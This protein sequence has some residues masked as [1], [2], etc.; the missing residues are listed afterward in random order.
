[1]PPHSSVA[2]CNMMELTIANKPLTTTTTTMVRNVTVIH[3][4]T[5]PRSRSTALLYSFEAR[6]DCVVLDEPL[7]RLFIS[8]RPNMHRVY[9]DNLVNGIAPDYEEEASSYKWAREL[10]PFEDRIQDAIAK[11][12]LK[13]KSEHE[14]HGGFIFCKHLSKQAT[15]Y[16]RA[17]FESKTIRQAL[18]ESGGEVRITHRHV[19]LL[20]DP[21]A[22]LS[23][24]DENGDIHFNCPCMEQVGIVP[25]LNIYASLQE[26]ALSKLKA[27]N[28]NN[29]NN[30]NND[31]IVFVDSDEL[32]ADPAGILADLCADVGISFTTEMLSWKSGSHECDGPWAPWWYASI[33]KSTH[34]VVKASEHAKAKIGELTG[35]V[36]PLY[37]NTLEASMPSYV[38][39]KI[40][41]DKDHRLRRPTKQTLP[42]KHVQQHGFVSTCTTTSTTTSSGGGNGTTGTEQ[43]SSMVWMDT[44]DRSFLAPREAGEIAMIP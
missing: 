23:S 9:K 22:I 42:N 39:L 40:L 31:A 21:V 12:K 34:W 43:Q 16:D 19:M 6:S 14:G 44:V 8:N 28:G 35:V 36:P 3:C 32:V 25:M 38:Y 37:M 41:C 27:A 29:D 17:A 7:H 18:V 4:W 2:N 1:M 10:V 15:A 11:L 13:S 33:Q 5:A 20:R 24:W 30:N 26:E